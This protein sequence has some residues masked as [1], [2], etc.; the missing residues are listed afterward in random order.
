MKAILMCN[1]PPNEIT[2]G[3]L[4]FNKIINDGIFP[5]NNY[6][7]N[8]FN[9]QNNRHFRKI[10]LPDY[11]EVISNRT[12]IDSELN[13][14]VSKIFGRIKYNS[15][16]ENFIIFGSFCQLYKIHKLMEK[17][18]TPHFYN[19]NLINYFDRN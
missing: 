3:R 13:T 16:K 15:F 18:E 2:L 7:E 6:T 17:H 19:G 4:A 9:K 11:F 8:T 12:S 5:V 10:V 1:E 14:C